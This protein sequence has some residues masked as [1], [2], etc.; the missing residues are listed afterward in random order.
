ME[1]IKIAED[2]K[3]VILAAYGD[4]VGTFKLQSVDE[5]TLEVNFPKSSA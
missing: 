5:E 1:S 3:G 4:R 2:L